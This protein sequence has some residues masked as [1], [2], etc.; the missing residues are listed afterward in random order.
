VILA[1]L[2]SI[3]D[4]GGEGA[5]ESPGSVEAVPFSPLGL[6]AALIPG[7]VAIAAEGASGVVVMLAVVGAAGAAPMV[8]GVPLR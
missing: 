1:G 5:L 7:G 2:P 6:G 4:W 3:S 8:S